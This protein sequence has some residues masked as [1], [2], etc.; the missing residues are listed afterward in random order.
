MNVMD[1]FVLILNIVECSIKKS[2]DMEVFV[3]LQ[4]FVSVHNSSHFFLE[5]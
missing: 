3:L 5:V 4:L 2:S 1:N